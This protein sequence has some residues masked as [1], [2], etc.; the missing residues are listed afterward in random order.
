MDREFVGVWDIIGEAERNAVGILYAD[1][2]RDYLIPHADWIHEVYT[3]LPEDFPGRVEE[4]ARSIIEPAEN[5]Y[6]RARLLEEYLLRFGYTLTPGNTPIDRDFVEYFLFYQQEGYCT[7]FASAFVTMARAVGLPARYVEGFNVT[8]WPDHEG[9]INVTNEQGHAW[10][11][12]YFEGFGWVR[13][14]PTPGGGGVP[15]DDYWGDY[16]PAFTEWEDF[17]TDWWEDM[18]WSWGEAGSAGNLR[19]EEA[20]AGLVPTATGDAAVFAL[21]NRFAHSVLVVALV[22]LSAAAARVVYVLRLR[23]QSYNHN[24][25]AA[26]VQGFHGILRYLKFFKHE[27]GPSE[28]AVQFARKIDSR[29][30]FATDQLRMKDIAGIFSKARYSG[31]SVTPAEREAVERALAALDARM[32]AY[33]GRLRY[34][35]YKYILAVV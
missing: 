25:S 8:G 12:V 22:L 23:R 28:T 32:L 30:E 7:Y 1:L 35:Y 21:F 14:E 27:I 11:E 5:D 13:F 15:F 34:L 3:R 26:V 29:S 24:N 6:E 9:F 20:Q 31:H 10:G 4:L 17:Y 18:M 16:L 2:L 33:S 19:Y